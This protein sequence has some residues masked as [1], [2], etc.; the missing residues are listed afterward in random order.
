[1]PLDDPRGLPCLALFLSWLSKEHALSFVGTCV[2]QVSLRG[3]GVTASVMAASNTIGNVATA[4]VSKL[5]PAPTSAARMFANMPVPSLAHQHNLA[6]LARSDTLCCA[7]APP[8]SAQRACS[9]T[10]IL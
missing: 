10:S 3:V 6:R 1:M 9:A 8:H 4:L 2:V 5:I 7:R